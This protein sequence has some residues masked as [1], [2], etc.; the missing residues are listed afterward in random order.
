MKI[1]LDVISP[2][3]CGG[4]VPREKAEIRAASLRGQLRWWFRLL[5][6]F[7]SLQHQGM[8][9]RQQEDMIFG[10]VR[11]A[12][13]SAGKLQVRTRL[14]NDARSAIKSFDRNDRAFPFGSGYFLFPMQNT[15]SADNSRAIFLQS[16]PKFE[17]FL[18]WR[19]DAVLVDDI[20]ALG[21]LYGYLG[22]LGMRSRRAMGALAFS[23]VQDTP[24]PAYDVVTSHFVTPNNI[25]VKEIPLQKSDNAISVLATWLR[26]W[27][28]YLNE[29]LHRNEG[30][31]GFMCAEEDHN[32]GYAPN[33]ENK[34]T[35]RPA[36]GL[37]I[38]QRLRQMNDTCHW[39]FSNQRGAA[40]FASPVI[41]RPSFNLDGTKKAL[42]I[43]V[44]AYTY[45]EGGRVYL[46]YKNAG[47]HADPK[48]HKVCNKLYQAM[49]NDGR[50]QPFLP[51]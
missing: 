18:N 8:D 30:A 34:Q 43:F 6:G 12:D 25:T 42:V 44:D 27:R 24:I 45:P 16:L 20:A 50:L 51:C 49:K 9:V 14:L 31:P 48:E 37:P 13:C 7:K 10:V 4:A 35:Y 11:G 15:R 22:S 1:N 21:Y 40:R 26:S 29:Q 3:L 36:L 19:G 46:H 33:Q 47:P 39:E 41:L 32:I 5:G 23:K 17:L 2:A 28:A 38:I